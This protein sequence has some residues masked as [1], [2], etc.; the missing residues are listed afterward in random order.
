MM[1]C[2]KCGSIL[3]PKSAGNKK[4]MACSCGYKEDAEEITI[5]E[6]V[7]SKDVE[8][9]D[10]EM[11]NNLPITENK[12]KKCGHKEA[13]FMEKQTRAADEPPTRFYKCVECGN[14]WRE[15]K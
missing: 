11:D 2:P 14:T 13:Y 15:Y 4:V 12:C 3:M 6:S 8:V 9:I 7:E 1:F 5:T 10:S